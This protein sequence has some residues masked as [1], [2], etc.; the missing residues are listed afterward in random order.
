LQTSRFGLLIL[1]SWDDSVNNAGVAT[2]GTTGAVWNAAEQSRWIDL[3]SPEVGE[4]TSTI[5]EYIELG[6][7]SNGTNANS[8]AS[9]TFIDLEGNNYPASDF[10]VSGTLTH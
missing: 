10:E 3:G 8:A 1:N 9:V 6:F 2:D 7:F 5:L 4:V